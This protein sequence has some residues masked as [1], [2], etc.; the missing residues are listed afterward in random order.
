M[1]VIRGDDRSERARAP[2]LAALQPD[3]A[4]DS[5]VGA[6]NEKGAGEIE[7]SY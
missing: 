2:R 4:P 1:G 3:A 6:I 5:V 7:R